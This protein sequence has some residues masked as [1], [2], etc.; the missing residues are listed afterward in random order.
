MLHSP[1]V[2]LLRLALALLLLV[3]SATSLLLFQQMER[4]QQDA[5]RERVGFQART[6]AIRLENSLTDEVEALR[7][8]AL[9]W[10]HRGRIPHDEWMLEAQFALDHFQ[11]YQSI[12]WLDS[13]LKMRWVQPLKGNEAARGFRLTPNHPNFNLAMQAKASGQPQ[14][15]NSVELVQ[16]GRGFVLY[17][18]L[19]IANDQSAQTFDGFLQGVFRVERLMDKLLEGLDN[20]DFSVRLLE[21]GK[22][23]YHRERPQS[24]NELEQQVPLHLLNNRHFALQLSPTSALV[25]QLSSPLPRFVFGAG[26]LTSLL[27]VAALALALENARRADALQTGYRRLNQEVRQREEAEQELR[28]S[29]ERL[30][31]VLDLTDSSRDGLF[32]LDLASREVLHMNQATYSSLGYSAEDFR[33]RLKD[34]PEHLLPGFHAWLESVHQAHLDKQSTIFQR[35]MRR[36]DG[37][38]QAAEI[39]AQLVKRNGREYLIGVSRDNRERLELEARLQRLSH[40]DGLTGL[41][42]RRHFDRQLSGEWRRL[43][44]VGAPLALLMLDVDHFKAFN[45]RLGHQAGDDALRRVAAVLQESLQREGDVACRYGGEEFAIILANTSEQGALNVAERVRQQVE[46]LGIPHPD[47][48]GGRLTLSIGI[49]VS[50]PAREE[51]PDS[52]VARSD[53]ALY[54]AKHEGR[55][56]TCLWGPNQG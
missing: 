33:Q 28:E 47:G 46:T 43:R 48:I 4:A 13:T 41:Y 25:K 15:S 36:S 26:L 19:Y 12:Q 17:T 54:R 35:E 18:P 21:S 53:A 2:W 51:Q 3:L 22:P 6:L 10:N 5:I 50:D 39:S 52:L 30:Q 8:M 31:L 45:D 38:L 49:A 34:D 23:L 32:I 42:N 44:R 20:E 27:L 40:Q 37:S 56:R 24:L 16:G 1:P 9:L 14:L 11:G 29:R 7:R 55:N